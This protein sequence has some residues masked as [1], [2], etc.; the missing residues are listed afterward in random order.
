[1][2]T[3]SDADR[4]A[5]LAKLQDAITQSS[6]DAVLDRLSTIQTE[7][8]ELAARPVPVTLSINDYTNADW[9]NGSFRKKAGLSLVNT[10]EAQAALKAGAVVTLGNG[11]TRKVASLQVIDGRNLSL[12]LEGDIVPSAVAATKKITVDPKAVVKEEVVETKPETPSVP[13]PEVKRNP[14]AAGNL[15]GINLASAAFSD[16]DP[17]ALPG[18]YG[19][20]YI[21]SDETHYKKW[22]KELGV[23]HIR[24][25]IRAER[26][27]PVPGGEL[28]AAEAS[29]ILQA[30]DWA[31]KYGQVVELDIHNYFKFALNGQ[32]VE[33]DTPKYSEAHFA[34]LWRR[35]AKLLVG[36][37]ALY[38]YGLCNEPKTLVGDKNTNGK[39]ARLAKAAA[40]AI[41]TI[42]EDGYIIIN[43]ESWASADRWRAQNPNFPLKGLKNVIYQ[44]HQY[45]DSDASGTYK[46]LNEKIDPQI[47]VKRL[48]DWVKWGKETGSELMLGEI[49]V[50]YNCPA[51][52][53]AFDNGLK[54]CADNN[55]RVMGYAGGPWWPKNSAN[56]MEA[57]GVLL[58]QVTDIM[59]KHQKYID[60][61]GP[62]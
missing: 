1:M 40:Q 30:Y 50:P 3:L 46:D 8:K 12:W 38:G 54:F 10:P 27:T 15:I 37:K 53:V 6:I 55:I 5:I 61:H 58:T 17:S 4:K 18:I 13:A 9:V 47:F 57:D 34:D 36:H 23:T 33:F 21:Y 56:A 2:A 28:N 51:G 31:A 39:W 49:G 43:G 7:L 20:H 25:C 35:L 14:R 16:H 24:L 62:N 22:A 19:K 11:E 59:K 60:H 32:W 26:I 44:A 42:D 52:L 41:R 45:A 48:Q 29:R